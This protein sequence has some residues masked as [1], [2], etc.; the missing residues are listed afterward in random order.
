M[1][2]LDLPAEMRLH[3]YQFMRK[4]WRNLSLSCKQCLN[5]LKPLLWQSITV[6]FVYSFD[7]I[8]DITTLHTNLHTFTKRIAFHCAIEQIMQR[9]FDDEDSYIYSKTVIRPMIDMCN[10]DSV[11]SLHVEVHFTQD[12]LKWVLSGVRNLRELT[13]S[14]CNEFGVPAWKSALECQ[15]LRVLT[16]N[17]GFVTN[18]E[19]KEIIKLQQLTE[20]HIFL[21]QEKGCTIVLED[22]FAFTNVD[23]LTVVVPGLVEYFP[24]SRYISYEVEE[25]PRLVHLD[26]SWTCVNN[27]W[28]YMFVE[29]AQNLRSLVCRS[30]RYLNDEILTGMC[31]LKSLEYLDVRFTQCTLVELRRF[32]NTVQMKELSHFV[33][34]KSK[35]INFQH[36]L[37]KLF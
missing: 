5:E 18:Y 3:L 1:D 19:F 29:G 30:C 14:H 7:Y 21:S 23:S 17:D 9:N 28:L 12:D 25:L 10:V 37:G 24:L 2:F 6:P 34:C 16:L 4:S 32:A 31:G 35:T 15:Q 13:L 36:K 11:T 33:Y 26:L 20:F 22:V 8:E 27:D